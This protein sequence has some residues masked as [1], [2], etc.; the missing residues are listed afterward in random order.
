MLMVNRRFHLT[1]AWDSLIQGIVRF[2]VGE[3]SMAGEVKRQF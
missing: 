3:V 1:N 2:E